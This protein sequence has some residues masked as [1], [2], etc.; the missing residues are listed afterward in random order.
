MQFSTKLVQT[1][2]KYTLL[3]GEW[4][5]SNLWKSALVNP[6]R[7]IQS[8]K[9]SIKM[10][11]HIVWYIIC[12]F[13]FFMLS[14]VRQDFLEQYSTGWCPSLFHSLYIF[15]SFV[16]YF[17]PLHAKLLWKSKYKHR[18]VKTCGLMVRMLDSLSL[19]SGFNYW[20]GWGLV[21]L[22]KICDF[23]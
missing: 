22:S 20:T 8:W 5:A 11:M 4:G 6:N 23:M 16:F 13:F 1:Q 9:S 21:S 12:F 19:D 17:M 2:R 14:C 3:G 18:Y 15:F 10:I 7:C